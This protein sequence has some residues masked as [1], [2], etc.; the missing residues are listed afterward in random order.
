[1]ITEVQNAARKAG[2][3][4]NS[5]D[6]AMYVRCCV[7]DDIQTAAQAYKR[8]LSAYGFVDPYVN[9]FTRYGFGDDMQGFRKLWQE[10]KRDEAVQ[11]ISDKM[12]H[13]LAAIGPKE[14]ARDY[15][16]AFRAAGLTHPILFPIGAPRN[17]AQEFPRA[18]QE[19]AEL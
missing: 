19:L 15:I 5:I 8:E 12:V 6:F 7:T 14:K 4:P 10:G 16:Q 17:A 11:C 18:M 2:R 13:T 1:M 3:D 9:M